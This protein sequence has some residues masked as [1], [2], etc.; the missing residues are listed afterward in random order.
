MIG[1]ITTPNIPDSTTVN[2]VGQYTIP[3]TGYSHNLVVT[4]AAGIT[5][6][7]Q[8]VGRSETISNSTGGNL[9]V[10][11]ADQVNDYI[12]PSSDYSSTAHTV[13][14]PN[15]VTVQ[16]NCNAPNRW[17][18]FSVADPNIVNVNG[19]QTITGPKSF[20]QPIKV[21]TIN[22]NTLDNGVNVAGRLFKNGEWVASTQTINSDAT[23]SADFV[24]YTGN[25][26]NNLTMPPAIPGRRI[27]LAAVGGTFPY[28]NSSQ[29][30]AD[31]TD[32]FCSTYDTVPTLGGDSITLYNGTAL[33]FECNFS[34]SWLYRQYN[35]L[36]KEWSVDHAGNIAPT[37][38][39]AN[40]VGTAA[41]G[42][43]NVN[44]AGA[45][46]TPLVSTRSGNIVFGTAST[47][48]WTL[49]TNG[50]FSPV[51]NN[52][53]DLGISGTNTVR[54]LNLGRDANVGRNLKINGQQINGY[55]A[56]S[57]SFTAAVADGDYYSIDTTSVA[58]TATL[59]NGTSVQAG[60]TICFKDSKGNAATNNI[61]IT[62]FSGQTIDGG[63][64]GAN[65]ISANYGAKKIRWDGISNWEVF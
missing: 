63:A 49:D 23:I 40:D 11:V 56:K 34:G 59:F 61:T 22:E 55:T 18:V 10:T 2:Q 9:V 14:I 51:S 20:T 52:T 41:S 35:A 12:D 43:R 16:I 44:V 21:D 6:P 38:N 65:K 36:S 62:P 45:V 13:T 57:A 19:G 27:V 50:H 42:I 4:Q 29:V 53:Y 48:R 5:L 58:V 64:T 31:G 30:Y 17:T 3:S 1:Q 33:I 26:S 7:T 24:K 37:T 47:N 60:Y 15:G 54:D 28:D 25:G 39:N 8:K 32:T 46:F